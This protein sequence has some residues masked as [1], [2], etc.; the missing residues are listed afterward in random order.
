MVVELKQA[1]VVAEGADHHKISHDPRASP[2]SAPQ[3][4]MH[5]L[6]R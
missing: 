3:T 5:S 2:V 1:D 4:S 6:E